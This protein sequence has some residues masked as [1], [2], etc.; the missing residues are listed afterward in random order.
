MTAYRPPTPK[1]TPAGIRPLHCCALLVL[2]GLAFLAVP[3]P[4]A[5]TAVQ[6]T[7]APAG[8]QVVHVG[9]YV[10]DVKRLSV[11][12]GTYETNFYLTL[13]SDR[14]VSLGDLEIMNGQISSASTITD[15]P[16]EKVYRIYGGMTAD[17]DLRKYPFDSHTLPIIIEAK[18]LPDTQLVLDIDKGNTSI[19]PEAN[20]PGWS[21]TGSS[22]SVTS[23][24]YVTDEIPY[25]RAVFA[26][27]ITRDAAS[28]VL[29][30]FLPI[31]LI[32][33]VSLASL[34]MKTASR[35]GLNASMFLAA[36]LIHW[37]IADAIPLV[38]YA[39]F[40]DYFMI[41]TYAT[42]VMVLISGILLLYFG[43]LK[44]TAKVEAINRWSLRLI[45]AV[46]LSLYLL[47]FV[48]LFF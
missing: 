16:T 10:V 7:H 35:L 22:A 40:L 3:V 2:L 19:D 44:E 47:L 14:N 21:I 43:E 20:L 24:R 28:T 13:T 25:S 46:S 12:D 38:A 27:S 37:R 8:P 42:L 1:G 15:T 26:A 6:D 48:S 29:K 31:L 34:L 33:I 23:E 45:P 39:T 11:A 5:N 36:V 17:P 4:A 30:F 9:V 18:E 41:L 32:I